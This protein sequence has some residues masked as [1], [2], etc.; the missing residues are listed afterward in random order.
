[1]KNHEQLI[2]SYSKHCTSPASNLDFP[3]INLI[4]SICPL[5]GEYW[6]SG[7]KKRSLNH[8]LTACYLWRQS[9][10]ARIF[11]LNCVCV[12]FEHWYTESLEECQTSIIPQLTFAEGVRYFWCWIKLHFHCYLCFLIMVY[13]WQHIC[14]DDH[15]ILHLFLRGY[16]LFCSKTLGMVQE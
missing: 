1:M 10:R 6:S 12:C 4:L 13:L 15:H 9:F 14:E 8:I 2:F 3:R 5:Q 16:V 11:Y 7:K